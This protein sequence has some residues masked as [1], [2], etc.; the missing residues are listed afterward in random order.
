M[1]KFG[2]FNANVFFIEVFCMLRNSN[3]YV[4]T[5]NRHYFLL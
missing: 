1:A 5:L 2:L 3:Y 4:F